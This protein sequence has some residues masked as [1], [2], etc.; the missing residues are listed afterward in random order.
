MDRRDFIA[1]VVAAPVVARIR[2]VSAPQARLS[3]YIF[4]VQESLY[5]AATRDEPKKDW[6]L[7]FAYHVEGVER[8]V[9]MPLPLKNALLACGLGMELSSSHAQ[10]LVIRSSL[11]PDAVMQRCEQV[12]ASR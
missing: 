7:Y 3:L 2:P 8:A 11:V 6:E 4:W 5:C 9:A 1:S 12:M 10:T